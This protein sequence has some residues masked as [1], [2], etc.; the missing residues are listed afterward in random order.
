[1]NDHADRLGAAQRWYLVAVL[2]A[3]NICGLVD[4]LIL[5]LLV[6]PLKQD[7]HVSDTQVSLLMGASFALLYSV[8]GIPV[9]RLADRR[10]RPA[11]LAGG[12]AL[13]SAMTALC[14]LAQT[15]T[16]LLI[17]RIG[18]G[19]GEA[20]LGPSAIS[21][22][23]DAFGP[24][25][26]SVALSVYAVGAFCG[27]GL[28]YVIGGWIAGHT[29]AQ[30]AFSVPLLGTV[31]PWQLV[32]FGVGA[33]GLIVAVLALMMREPP[34]AAGMTGATFAE[35]LGYWRQHAGTFVSLSC[36][37]GCWSAVN[38]GIAAWLATFFVRTH[39]WTAATAG[40]W[41]GTLTMTVGVTGA[42]LGGWWT[43]RRLR[44]GESDAA[45][46]VARLAALGLLVTGTAYPLVG[47]ATI[48]AALLI[49]VNLCA[50]VPWGAANAAIATA[51]PSRMRGQGAALYLLVINLS[52][53]VLGPTS[54][55]LFTDYVF[56]VRAGL[57]FALATVT[58]FGMATAIALLTL[59]APAYRRTVAMLAEPSH[60]SVR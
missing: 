3:A 32:F 9:G 1:V 44:A 45:L 37:F 39:G 12:I 60:V 10:S 36:A 7:L 28:A 41:Q 14:G 22:I 23:G 19:I 31:R 50:A 38:Y 25:R 27:A 6:E 35:V 11:I 55:A 34:R 30:T 17:F 4:R 5:S 57:P 13:W 47:S 33:P 29:A 53:G 21:L 20:T 2:T 15:Y 48:A 43:D 8:L 24:G 46:R 42:L 58:A 59:G 49:P 56:G 18:V 54:V 51:L 16:Q 26:R 40:T 52:S